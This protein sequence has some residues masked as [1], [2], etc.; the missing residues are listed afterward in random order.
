[1]VGNLGSSITYPLTGTSE[2]WFRDGIIRDPFVSLT[3][4]LVDLLYVGNEW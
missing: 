3:N 4:W 2:V 1:M